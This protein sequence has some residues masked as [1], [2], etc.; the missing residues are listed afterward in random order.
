MSEREL[1][2]HPHVFKSHCN[3]NSN[4]NRN[5]AFETV[6]HVDGL[7]FSRHGKSFFPKYR[8]VEIDSIGETWLIIIPKRLS[9][10]ALPQGGH[11][12]THLYLCFRRWNPVQY[13]P[14]RNRSTYAPIFGYK[15]FQRLHKTDGFHK[16]HKRRIIVLT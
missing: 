15:Q 14:T 6:V 10:I 16:Y 5:H 8:K 3:S 7:S 1:R 9:Y 12:H 4:S 2:F 13:T 11:C